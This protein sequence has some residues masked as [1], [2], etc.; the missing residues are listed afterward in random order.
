IAARL[1]VSEEDVLESTEARTL[2]RLS[3]LDADISDDGGSTVE[4]RFGADDRELDAA[5]DRLAVGRLLATVP[6]RER[7]I[8]YLRV[9]EG[10]TQSEI[11]AEVGISQ[12]HVSRLLSKSLAALADHDA[13][14]ASS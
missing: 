1:G 7:R 2:Y 12:M 6:P 5:D 9:F 11:A 4:N 13:G 14:A 8:L 3:S 10:M